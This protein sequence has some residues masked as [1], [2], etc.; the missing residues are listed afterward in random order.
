MKKLLIGL[1]ALVAISAHAE[2]NLPSEL[3][4]QADTTDLQETPEYLKYGTPEYE[5][6]DGHA[7]LSPTLY[8]VIASERRVGTVTEGN[9]IVVLDSS[10]VTPLEE[11][12]DKWN[13]RFYTFKMNDGKLTLRCDVYF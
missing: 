3:Y 4:C 12:A 8:S 1:L 13:P 11:K 9:K 2:N 10:E 5:W 7:L 6:A